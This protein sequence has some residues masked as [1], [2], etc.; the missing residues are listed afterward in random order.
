M[1]GYNELTL[2]GN[3]P[4]YYTVYILAVIKLTNKLLLHSIQLSLIYAIDY[5]KEVCYFRILSGH[6]AIYAVSVYRFISHRH[7][8][9]EDYVRLGDSGDGGWD[10]CLV[11]PYRLEKPCLVYSFGSVFCRTVYSTLLQK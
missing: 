10:V 8:N 9:C 6:Y 4:Y 3:L 5:S 7:Y 2:L 1:V 11:D